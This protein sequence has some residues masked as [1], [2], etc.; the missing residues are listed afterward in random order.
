M[1]AHMFSVYGWYTPKGL[2]IYKNVRQMKVGEI[3]AVSGSGISSEMIKFKPLEIEDYSDRDLET[4]YK[5]LRE[6]V[7]SRANQS[8]KTWVSSSSGWDSSLILGLLVNEFG[9]RNIGMITGSMKYSEGTDVINKFEINKI[10]KI[11]NSMV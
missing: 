7:V 4:Y 5:I 9:S 8:G 1:L 11:G 2:T 3:I 10:K 6:S